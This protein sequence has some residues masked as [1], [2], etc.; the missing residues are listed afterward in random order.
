MHPVAADVSLLHLFGVSNQSRLTSAATVQ[1]FEARN[2]FR[3]ILSPSDDPSQ[4]GN[5][6][7]SAPSPAPLHQANRRLR[8][9][10]NGLSTNM[11]NSTE[12]AKAAINRTGKITHTDHGA[13][14]PSFNSSSAPMQ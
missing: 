6:D 9:A 7:V 12:A 14:K 13:P 4:D 1:G 10:V 8:I 11:W 5:Y 3:R 2:W